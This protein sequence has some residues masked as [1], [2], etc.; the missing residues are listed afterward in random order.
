MTTRAPLA[1]ALTL[2]GSL[3]LAACATG[4]AAGPEPLTPTSR[5]TLQV[6]P[7]VD[8]IALAVREDGLS[9]AQTAALDALA[10]RHGHRGVGAVSVA[11]PAGEDPAAA[12]TAWNIRDALMARGLPPEAIRMAGYPAPDPRAPVV[13]S[14][15]T[16]EARVPAC[17]RAWEDLSANANRPPNNFGCAL[18][19][20][21]AAQIADP[22]DILQPRAMPAQDSHR[23]VVVF[24]N[25]RQGRQTS[26]P[27]EELV[28]GRVTQAVE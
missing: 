20:N 5:W 21:M 11:A 10:A 18:T 8:Q 16:V 19:A 23:A 27:Q 17:G 12:R 13:V 1:V 4:P 28:S 22:R 24:D 15:E 26:A 25:Y 9:S 14:F 3:A 6:Q 2:A 7:G